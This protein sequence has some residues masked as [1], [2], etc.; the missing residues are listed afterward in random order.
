LLG[1][2][3]SMSSVVVRGAGRGKGIGYPTVNLAVEDH[4]KL[5]PPDGV[6]AV[7]VEWRTGSS[8]GMM[9]QGARPTFDETE[10]SIEAHVF[11]LQ[12]EVYGQRVRLSWVKRLRDVHRFESAEALKRQLDKDFAAAKVALTGVGGST[13]Y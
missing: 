7:H 4:R 10:R 1:R 2:P 6:Y 13:S 5:L 11:A 12:E 8:G 3:Y 9:H